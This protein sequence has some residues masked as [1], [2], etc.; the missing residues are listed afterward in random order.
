[1]SIT[2]TAKW[3]WQ[4]KVNAVFARANALKE[5][6]ADMLA[7]EAM[8]MLRAGGLSFTDC[9]DIMRSSKYGA[10]ALETGFP[11]CALPP[12]RY[13]PDPPK[14]KKRDFWKPPI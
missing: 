7:T 9:S 10:H 5:T 11:L 2:P 6:P 8:K 3:Q 13:E 12:G 1:M 14:P 4:G